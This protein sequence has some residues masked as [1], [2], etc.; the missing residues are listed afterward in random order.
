MYC[1]NSQSYFFLLIIE[2][3][4]TELGVAVGCPSHQRGW[5]GIP[6]LSAV[7]PAILWV[8]G[9][10]HTFGFEWPFYVQIFI[11]CY[12]RNV[13]LIKRDIEVDWSLKIGS[14]KICYNGPLSSNFSS[15]LDNAT[16]E[17]GKTEFCIWYSF[18]I[19]RHKINGWMK[20]M[21]KHFGATETMFI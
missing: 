14:F 13:G 5:V 21:V 1:Q 20:V 3:M 12:F 2:S 17:T 19:W 15:A 18:R 9:G 8:M 7:Y 10:C 16:F 6:F 11:S 4:Q